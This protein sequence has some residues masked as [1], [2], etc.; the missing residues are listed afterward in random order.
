MAA[1]RALAEQWLLDYHM[2]MGARGYPPDNV[3][4]KKKKF[5]LCHYTWGG[6]HS[7][8]VVQEAVFW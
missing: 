8:M 4:K 7:D 3:K 6:A 5:S 2:V 1:T